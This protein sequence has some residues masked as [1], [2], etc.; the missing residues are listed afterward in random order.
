MTGTVFPGQPQI[1][2][3]RLEELDRRHTF[4]FTIDTVDVTFYVDPD[5][6]SMTD[7]EGAEID[8][9]YFELTDLAYD[10]S[11]T[12]WQEVRWTLDPGTVNEL[13]WFG[14]FVVSCERAGVAGGP[15]I[16][17]RVKC[18]G[19]TTLLER[20]EAPEK[21]YLDQYPGDIAADLLVTAGLTKIYG[22]AMGAMTY[23]GNDTTTAE[24]RYLGGN[25]SSYA[26]TSGDAAYALVATNEDGSISWGYMGGAN[27]SNQDI[28]IYTDRA[29]TTRGWL[30]TLPNAGSHY[31]EQFWVR[32][33]AEFS[34]HTPINVTEHV[35]Q[36]ASKLTS[37]AS[38][39]EQSL[40]ATLARLAVEAGSWA[41]RIDAAAYLWFAPAGTDAAP[42]GVSDGDS[43]DF[44]NYW[45]VRAETFS[46]VTSGVDM[47]NRV[48][49][50]G[51][52]KDSTPVT[53]YFY[54]TGSKT[55]YQLAHRDLIEITVILNGQVIADG[56]MWWHTFADGKVVLV[57]YAEGWIWFNVAPA[58]TDELTVIYRYW[59]PLV[60]EKRNEASIVARRQVLTK[61]IVDRS[62]YDDERAEVVATAILND[63]A[64]PV[65]SGS[66]E[67][68][69]LGLRAGQAVTLEFPQF[70]LSDDFVI[71]KLDCRIDPSGDG[72]IC[73]VQYGGRQTSLS[74]LV[75]R[76]GQIST[77]DVRLEQLGN[78]VHRASA[79]P[80]KPITSDHL[81]VKGETVVADASDGALSVYLPPPG[82]MIDR[83]VPVIMIGGKNTVTVYGDT[84]NG[85]SSYVLSTKYQAAIF[86]S[87]GAAWY[88]IA[89]APGTP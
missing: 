25:F 84:I 81:V 36:G 61:T 75:A 72:L 8:T 21:F 47:V 23:Q 63:Y 7:A 76:G 27:N 46:L 35:T 49:V 44:V 89:T 52:A 11:I 77:R 85:A 3:G 4:R 42:F 55:L 24:F 65:Q 30:G 5:T 45:P 70:G 79:A 57:N 68:W 62:I 78:L 22:S 9:L 31:P 58:L 50:H 54:G 88:V 69:R 2:V 80:A 32:K 39:R 38:T 37:F 34:G 53:E 6:V 28:D 13:E 86:Y 29:R 33:A 71:R 14:G 83:W 74:E 59:T 41:W 20:M 56:T 16:L 48:V 73:W 87:T 12:E 17:W 40:A 18:E 10:L 43:G 60:Y 15:G 82:A 19:Y 26:T 66:F 51:G 67:V 64:A 1:P